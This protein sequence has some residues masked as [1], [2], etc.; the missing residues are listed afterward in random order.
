MLRSL[1]GLFGYEIEATDGKIGRVHDFFF[2]DL[3]W[4]VR[5]IVV[6][7]GKWLPGRKVLISPVAVESAHWAEHL[8][9]VNLDSETIKD[10]P[11]VDCEKPVS[12]Q[13]EENIVSHYRW[14]VYWSPVGTLTPAMA[15]MREKEAEGEG[16]EKP[17]AEELEKMNEPNL[18]DMREV[19]GY[20]IAAIDGDI[21]HS[22]DLIVDDTDWR[23]RYLVVDTGNWI[24][25]RKV[26]VSPDWIS[27]ITWKDAHVV[28]NLNR[29]MI[30]ESPE[31]D[32]GQPVNR[33][34]EQTLYDYY[35]R[36]YYWQ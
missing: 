14:P 5:Y 11:D 36:P 2:D 18:R 22:D 3:F 28:V 31:Y 7:T 4:T 6:D 17:A 20:S 33:V 30:R 27:H 13:I 15:A 12:R 26:L 29:E 24:P 19:T 23:I 16:E 10:S 8:L 1:K 34:L 35:G 21:G 32:P 9:Q 25:G